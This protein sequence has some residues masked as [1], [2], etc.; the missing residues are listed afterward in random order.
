MKS[1]EYG[2]DDAVSVVT[3]TGISQDHL[4]SQPSTSAS[5][6]DVHTTDKLMLLF[7]D[8]LIPRQISMVFKLSGDSFEL[9]FDCLADGPML[10]LLL[11]LHNSH[12]FVR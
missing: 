4:M 6:S 2:P 5:K 7:S 1:G 10:D 8:M 12:Y 3:V 11:K 9:P